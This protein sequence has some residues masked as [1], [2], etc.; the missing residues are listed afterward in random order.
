MGRGDANENFAA[1]FAVGGFG[2]TCVETSRRGKIGLFNLYA[3][4]FILKWAARP[5]IN[6]RF[7]R[8]QPITV[9]ALS[10]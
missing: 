3:G 10:H 8:P 1:A 6:V 9:Q 5:E 2:V 4:L 7:A